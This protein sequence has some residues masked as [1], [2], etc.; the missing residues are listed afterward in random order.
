MKPR[1]RDRHED[2]N[3]RPEG[4]LTLFALCHASKSCFE[5]QGWLA[6]LRSVRICTLRAESDVA[7]SANC[8]TAPKRGL[9]VASSC[10]PTRGTALTGFALTLRLFLRIPPWRRQGCSPQFSRS[11]RRGQTPHCSR[12]SGAPPQRPETPPRIE[13]SGIG[14]MTL[15]HCERGLL[16]RRAEPPSPTLSCLHLPSRSKPRRSAGKGQQ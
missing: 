16:F 8:P 15:G 5:R 7:R 6:P 4:E 10:A 13:R 11:T 2:A 3:V 1:G 9:A 12:H 14:G